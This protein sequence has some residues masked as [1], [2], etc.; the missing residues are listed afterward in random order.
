MDN[1]TFAEGTAFGPEKPIYNHLRP[2]KNPEE[3]I[4]TAAQAYDLA[5]S[6]II[7]NY[8]RVMRPSHER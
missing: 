3:F 5:S 2:R 1:L 8:R 6:D 4:H 7:Y